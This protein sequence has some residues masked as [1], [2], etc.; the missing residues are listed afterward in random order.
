MSQH[1]Q[2]LQSL[3]VSFICLGQFRSRKCYFFVFNWNFFARTPTAQ[4]WSS[5]QAMT[6]P[7]KQKQVLFQL[8]NPQK[9]KQA[10]FQLKNRSKSLVPGALLPFASNCSAAV[11][12][13]INFLARLPIRGCKVRNSYVEPWTRLDDLCSCYFRSFS[14][15]WHYTSASGYSWHNI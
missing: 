7:K 12:R 8:K 11:C 2:W 3:L 9:P 15:L 1:P 13:I 5:D 6:H 4:L 10:L 14:T